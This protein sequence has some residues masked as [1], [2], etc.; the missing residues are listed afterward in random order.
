MTVGLRE[1]VVE[2]RKTKK[3]I[4]VIHVCSITRDFWNFK[5]FHKPE[6][7]IGASTGWDHA[8]QVL[9]IIRLESG[10]IAARNNS[11]IKYDTFLRLPTNYNLISVLPIPNIFKIYLIT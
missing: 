11:R 5:D 4:I 1:G 9:N 8:C 3:A 2:H 7:G 10:S 6:I